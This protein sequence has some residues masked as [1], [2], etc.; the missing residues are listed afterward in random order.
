MLIPQEYVEAVRWHP[1]R[2]VSGELVP[3]LAALKVVAIDGVS[4]LYTCTKP[5]QNGLPPA[6][7]V[8]N[9]PADL[10]EGA[11]G[12]CTRD[13]P[14]TALYEA[15]DGVPAAGQIWGTKAGEWKLRLGQPGF[16][17]HG[18]VSAE[19]TR[20]QVVLQDAAGGSSVRPVY[21]TGPAVSGRFPARI[22][23]RDENVPNWLPLDPFLFVWAIGYNNET[24]STQKRYKGLQVS[25]NPAD[26]QP[27]Y[28]VTEATVGGGRTLS[29][30]MMLE[31]NVPVGA[32]E[33]LE[34]GRI[35]YDTD[36]YVWNNKTFRV[37]PGSYKVGV[38]FAHYFG[39]LTPEYPSVPIATIDATRVGGGEPPRQASGSLTLAPPLSYFTKIGFSVILNL[40]IL[41]GS[42]DIGVA[43]FEYGG[44]INFFN[45]RSIWGY[46]YELE[47]SSNQFWIERF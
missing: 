17:I 45:N 47:T 12:H 7:V 21:V 16:E 1:F 8:F 44:P 46:G 30:A 26:G 29:G 24:L 31:A 10:D 13:F 43:P 37:G 41:N 18:G 5:D 2:N 34:W 28:A 32:P 42:W 15:N 3:A 6:R 27:V 19:Q 38:S 11:Y 40:R 25:V 9:G 20:V 35:D 4:G 22:D 33:T 23:Y 14:A 39:L 36:N